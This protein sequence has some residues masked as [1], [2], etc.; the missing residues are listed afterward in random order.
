MKVLVSTSE[1]SIIIDL[2]ETSLEE[3]FIC[4]E[5]QYGIK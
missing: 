2:E 5:S 3:W 1:Y 4:L